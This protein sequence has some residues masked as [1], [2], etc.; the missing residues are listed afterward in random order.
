MKWSLQNSAHVMTAVLSSHVQKFVA[1]WGLVIELLQY[2]VHTK[3]E[4]RQSFLVKWDPGPELDWSSSP[5]LGLVA[6]TT[7]PLQLK[8]DGKFVLLIHVSENQ[9][10][11]NFNTTMAAYHSISTQFCN[12]NSIRSWMIAKLIL[13]WIWINSSDAGDGT[14][15]LCGSIPCLLM[16]RHGISCVRQTTCIVI[17][18]LISLTRVKPNPRVDSKFFLLSFK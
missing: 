16:S 4:F 18:E 3:F 14:F 9:D 8:F 1:L 11:T 2:E 12:V 15:Q 7:F 5:L 17:P 6:S 13:Y 10:I